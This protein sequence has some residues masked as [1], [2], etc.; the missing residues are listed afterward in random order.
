MKFQPLEKGLAELLFT[1]SIA[2]VKYTEE[3]DSR[4][5][6]CAIA[7]D[8]LATLW[9]MSCS[10]IHS[11]LRRKSEG[12]IRFLPSWRYTLGTVAAILLVYY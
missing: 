8:Y 5:I 2:L 1:R 7:E 11:P 4:R 10:F 9:P 3:L 12:C 6:A